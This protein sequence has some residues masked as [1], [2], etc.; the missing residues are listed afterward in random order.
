MVNSN[1]QHRFIIKSTTDIVIDVF[2]FYF[3]L[4]IKGRVRLRRPSNI[5]QL[6]SL[7]RGRESRRTSWPRH[8]A[9]LRRQMECGL[10]H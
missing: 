6:R 9:F 4:Q 7:Q 2:A 5:P 3:Q 10:I 1:T 8:E